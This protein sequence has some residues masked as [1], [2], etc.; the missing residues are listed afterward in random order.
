VAQPL[1]SNMVANSIF[2]FK[3]KLNQLLRI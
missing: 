3:I 2:L 1:I